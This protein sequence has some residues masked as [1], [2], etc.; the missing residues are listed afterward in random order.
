MRVLVD[1]A[2]R[3]TGFPYAARMVTEAETELGIYRSATIW[4]ELKGE[5][6]LAEADR[7]LSEIRRRGDRRAADNWLKIIAAVED[8]QQRE[9]IVS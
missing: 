2:R 7:M 4:L 1:C 9:A 6:A 5:N 3:E 8:L